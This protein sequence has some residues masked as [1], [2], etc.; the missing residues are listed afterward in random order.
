MCEFEEIVYPSAARLAELEKAF[1]VFGRM[2]FRYQDLEEWVRENS[3]YAGDGYFFK[4]AYANI[5]EASNLVTCRAY[6][7]GGKPDVGTDEDGLNGAYVWNVFLPRFDG[8]RVSLLEPHD[9][10]AEYLNERLDVTEDAA[11]M[12]GVSTFLEYDMPILDDSDYSERED[13]VLRAFFHA[14]FDATLPDDVSE[15]DIYRAWWELTWPTP[16]TCDFDNGRVP[17]FIEY[18]RHNRM[19][20]A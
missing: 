1:N 8:M 11:F 12:Y 13:R 19:A 4:D 17:E 3:N 10:N 15:E 6:L 7:Y 20:Y 16:D 14:S 9:W 5:A 18:V 2:P